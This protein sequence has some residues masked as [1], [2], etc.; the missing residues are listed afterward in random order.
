L[1][2]GVAE[3]ARLTD[4]RGMSFVDPPRDSRA[5]Q[6]AL[7]QSLPYGVV[8]PDGQTVDVHVGA[9]S[10]A[11]DAALT[12]LRVGCASWAYLTAYNP[13]AVPASDDDNRRAAAELAEA[14]RATGLPT[15]P[16][17]GG[18]GPDP[19]WPPEPSVVVGGLDL[20]AAHA[21][22]R[23]FGQ[24][25]FLYARAGAPIALVEVEDAAFDAPRAL[26]TV[27]WV[28][29]DDA[30]ACLMARPR[31][32]PLYFM[33]GGKKEPGENDVDALARELREELGVELD[34]RAVVARFVVEERAFGPAE[35]TVVRMAC[36][37]GPC[38]GTPRPSAE[39]DELAWL[40][41]SDADQVPPAGRAVL[42]RLRAAR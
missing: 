29:V 24:A 27:A 37:A 17:T 13:H 5:R 32:K 40:D 33:P 9:R 35:P 14:V 11:V 36:Y 20:V 25:A 22:A 28:H 15:L 12:G 23:R 4:D 39:I 10:P 1:L 7:W 19:A 42:R 26:D 21:L 38:A 2:T 34:R 16:A 31:G 8:L 41:V 6:R 18:R 30:G 3:P